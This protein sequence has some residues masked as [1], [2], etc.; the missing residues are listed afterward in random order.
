MDRIDER[1]GE[2]HSNGVIATQIAAQAHVQ[3][4]AQALGIGNRS[5][6]DAIEQ[7]LKEIPVWITAKQSSGRG[8]AKYATLK[9]ILEVVRPILLKHRVRIRQGADRSWPCDEGG[10]TKGRLVPV[11]T[12]LIHVVTGEIER[13]QVEMPLTRLDPQAMGSAITYGKR[14]TI[15][16]ALGL[17]TDEA[18]DDGARAMPRDVTAAVSATGL[19]EKLKAEITA[20]KTKDALIAWGHDSKTTKRTNELS[21]DE[22]V[23]LRQHYTQRGQALIAE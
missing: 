6:N 7:A 23:L 17:A 1:T 21:D 13:T 22:A 4:K 10:G 11:Y 18:D 20:C 15:I 16:A 12:D 19:L 8:N 14:Y 2:I 3:A 5:L 9:E